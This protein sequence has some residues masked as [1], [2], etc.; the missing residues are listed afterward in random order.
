MNKFYYLCDPKI[1]W[2]TEESCFQPVHWPKI[3]LA[4]LPEYSRINLVKNKKK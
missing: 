3:E 4:G 1:D 2:Q